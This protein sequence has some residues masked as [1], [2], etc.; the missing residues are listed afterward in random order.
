M[1]KSSIKQS[2]N[3][4]KVVRIKNIKQ[5]NNLKKNIGLTF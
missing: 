3:D 2:K 5:Y 4:L 1:R